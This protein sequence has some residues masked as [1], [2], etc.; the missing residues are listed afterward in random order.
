MMFLSG[1]VN[2][3]NQLLFFLEISREEYENEK[4][5]PPPPPT[6]NKNVNDSPKNG[7]N[8]VSSNTELLE[9]RIAHV[10]HSLEALEMGMVRKFHLDW[11]KNKI[12]KFNS[13]PAS[14]SNYPLSCFVSILT[15][16]FIPTLFF[17][18]IKQFFF[19]NSMQ[20]VI[21]NH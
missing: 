15:L 13:A 2:N 1:Q 9:D 4:N 10:T 11:S 6:S 20:K 3:K 8:K 21:L 14:L 5:L 18:I 12:K 19:H 7:F 17:A 16:C